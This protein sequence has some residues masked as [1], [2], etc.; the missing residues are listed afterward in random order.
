MAIWNSIHKD[1]VDQH[2]KKI[3]NK[4]KLIKKVINVFYKN[5]NKEGGGVEFNQ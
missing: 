2:T 5:N 4:K 3:R 1:Q